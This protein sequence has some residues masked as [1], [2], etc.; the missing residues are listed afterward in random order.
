MTHMGQVRLTVHDASA[1]QSKRSYTDGGVIIIS[2][3]SCFRKLL[4]I[5]P[6]QTSL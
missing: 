5:N 1:V 2:R 4:K 6:E 3:A